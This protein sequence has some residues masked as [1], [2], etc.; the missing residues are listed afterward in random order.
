MSFLPFLAQNSLN[1]V[2]PVAAADH[3]QL[4]F[5]EARFSQL[6]N[7]NRNLGA[8]LHALQTGVILIAVALHGIGIQ[9]FKEVKAEAQ[10]FYTNLICDIG[11][12]VY[13]MVNILL[14]LV[15]ADKIT[16]GIQPTRP[17]VSLIALS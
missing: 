9:E 2:C 3:F 5:C 1:Q 16:E 12:M 8:V 14:C 7:Q 10:M 15:V 13:Q 17:L 4:L 11:S 6:F